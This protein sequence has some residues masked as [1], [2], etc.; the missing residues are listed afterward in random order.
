[1]NYLLEPHRSSFIWRLKKATG[2]ALSHR[3][4]QRCMILS[5]SPSF[6]LSHG[7]AAGLEKEN[8][9]SLIHL[10]ENLLSSFRDEFDYLGNNVC[11]EE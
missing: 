1:M 2:I 5:G 7:K 8:L 11:Y 3:A 9:A 4:I 6:S 10:K